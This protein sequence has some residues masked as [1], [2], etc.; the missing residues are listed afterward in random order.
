MVHMESADYTDDPPPGL[1]VGGA[2]A[3]ATPAS[4]TH[5]STRLSPTST[6][7][8]EG[9][10]PAQGG[11]AQREGIY[12]P[13]PM[14]PQR[15]AAAGAA[16]SA[17]GGSAFASRPR[18]GEASDAE[19]IIERLNSMQISYDHLAGTVRIRQRL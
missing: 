16:E 1:G 19:R 11:E 15:E 6:T 12:I 17:V 9:S 4:V 13:F 7:R 8:P 2:D 18:R 14:R 10:Q 3:F 5:G